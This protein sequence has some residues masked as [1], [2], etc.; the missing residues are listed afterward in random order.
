ML[1]TG[2]PLDLAFLRETHYPGMHVFLFSAFAT[3]WKCTSSTIPVTVERNRC[4]AQIISDFR[5]FDFRNQQATPVQLPCLGRHA[6]ILNREHN[7]YDCCKTFLVTSC[8]IYCQDHFHFSSTNVGSTFA[9]STFSRQ[10]ERY[11]TTPA[12]LDHQ[13]NSATLQQRQ[14]WWSRR[15]LNSAKNHKEL[16]TSN[17]SNY[18]SSDFL[19]QV[20]SVNC[21]ASNGQ[22]WSLP[23]GEERTWLEHCSHSKGSQPKSL[24]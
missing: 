12:V 3:Y 23:F 2:H 17:G 9:F 15:Q 8:L 4:R 14:S 18:P 11:A 22:G 19:S 13:L 10:H 6:I 7:K 1:R 5:I 20:R 16:K 24:K 21:V